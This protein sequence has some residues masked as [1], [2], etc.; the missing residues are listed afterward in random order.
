MLSIVFTSYTLS[1]LS[2]IYKLLES[3]EN[4]TYDNIEVIFVSDN[5]QKLAS[6]VEDFANIGNFKRFNLKVL[7]S[8]D[9]FGVNRCRNLGISSSSGEFIGVVDDD[10]ALFPRWAEEIV[11]DFIEDPAVVAITGPALPMWEDPKL[12]SWFPE[13]LYFV[14]GCTVW[15]WQEKREIRSVGGMNCGFRR[16][17]LF[18]VGL[19]KLGIGPTGGEEKIRWL[20]P[21]GE[22]IELS[23]RIKQTYPDSKIIYDP[24]VKIFH[25][26][27]RNRFN[28][29]FLTKRIFRFGYTRNYISHSFRSESHFLDLEKDHMRRIVCISSYQFLKSLVKEPRIALK[30]YLTIFVGI[31]FAALGYLA[32]YLKPY[33]KTERSR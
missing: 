24:L 1:R 13:E 27:E 21:S 17:V 5:S 22:E 7:V 33:H 10:T 29:H 11:K 12:M 23:L 9:K 25:K 18:Q 4:Q 16:G 8:R 2:D 14:W 30:K 6:E 3:I 31:F 15:S 19:Y 28:V 26:A 32:Y 20:Y